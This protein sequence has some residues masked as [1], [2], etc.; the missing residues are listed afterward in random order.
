DRGSWYARPARRPCRGLRSRASRSVRLL[1]CRH[2]HAGAV[3]ARA[4]Q[5]ADGGGVARLS[6]PQS[7]PL[8]H[9]YAHS[10]RGPPGRRGNGRRRAG[11]L[12]VNGLTRRSLLA[13]GGL[14]V[15]FASSGTAQAQEPEESPNLP[16][17]LDRYPFL[18]S[19]IRID[20][21]GRITVFT[22]KAELG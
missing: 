19:W 6:R 20:T 9:A 8:R 17:D 1:H 7:L 16:G 14:V 3:P 11:V 22:G 12:A 18:D 13:Q 5:P 21:A 15:V 4:Q 10:A 2:D